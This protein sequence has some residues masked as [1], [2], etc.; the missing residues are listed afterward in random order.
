[1]QQ[2]TINNKI[3]M[4]N[5]RVLAEV[6]TS[7]QARAAGAPMTGSTGF[8]GSMFLASPGMR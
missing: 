7:A 2:T 4:P 5:G 6:V 8:D 3:V 1:M